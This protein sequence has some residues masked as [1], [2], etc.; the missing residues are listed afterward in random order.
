MRGKGAML[1]EGKGAKLGEGGNTVKCLSVKC[2]FIVL[3]VKC[4]RR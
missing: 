4:W 1:G 3:S 2:M